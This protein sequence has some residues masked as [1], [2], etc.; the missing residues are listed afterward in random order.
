M[1]KLTT[2]FFCLLIALTVYSQKNEKNPLLY[3]SHIESSDGLEYKE[4]TY[5]EN[6]LSVSSEELFYDG[7]L[8]VDS[9]F[10]NDLNQV[11]RTG[12]YQ[13]INGQWIN[14][15]YIDYT[16][17][18]NGMRA[19][20][21]NYNN[22]GSGFELGGTYTYS[23]DENNNLTYWE[24]DFAGGIYQTCNRTY[25]ELNQVVQEI[26][27][28]Y[29][30]QS[31]RI[32]Y[33]YDSDNRLIS[34]FDYFWESGSWGFYSKT[35]YT[36]DENSNSVLI[37]G[38]TGN[39]LS[40]YSEFTFDE[41]F[42][43]DQVIFPENPEDEWPTFAPMQNIVILEKHYRLDNNGQMQYYCDYVYSYEPIGGDSPIITVSPTSLHF[44]AECCTESLEGQLVISNNGTLSGEYSASVIGENTTWLNITNATTGTV[45]PGETAELNVEINYSSL[46]V[47]DYEAI[48]KIETNDPNN[49]EIEVPVTLAVT[50]GLN[51]M[52]QRTLI[53]PNPASNFVK[54]QS[55][56]VQS[57]EIYNVMGK[58]M[59][60]G[61]MYEGAIQV[62]LSDLSSG[63]YLINLKTENETF[64]SKLVVE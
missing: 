21:K 64:I 57:I 10:Y 23:Y 31:W 1:K 3:F 37:Q 59:F 25:N 9:L 2:L 63:V 28:Q 18:E 45:S 4:F 8:V 61:E 22:F 16:Y 40:Q 60:S 62:D 56:G 33:S 26:G 19:T 14:V 34:Q 32:D 11:V 5:N 39:M 42:T 24:L 55:E 30:E 51:E 15:N 54:I 36:Y 38:Y 46:Y 48:I 27:Y 35:L 41:S 53:Y 58:L 7:T 13:L 20:R 17:N 43:L 50:V 44:D 12:A 49:L 29:S 47:G 52:L 6:M